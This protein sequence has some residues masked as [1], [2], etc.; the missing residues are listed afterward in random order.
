MK[1]TEVQKGQI[2][3][4][5]ALAMVVLLGFTAVAVDGS[6]VYNQRRQ[7]QA[8]AD[9][10]ALSYAYQI[11]KAGFTCPASGVPSLSPV[12]TT[13][14]TTTVTTTYPSCTS[15][16]T[17]LNIHTVVASTVNTYFLKAVTNKPTSTTVDA[18]AKVTLG[19][20]TYAGGNAIYTTGTNCSEWSSPYG[21][22]FVSGGTTKIQITDGGIFS[23]SCLSATG[24][25]RILAYGGMIQYTGHG[26]TTFYAGKASE[27]PQIEYTTGTG[28][29][30]TNTD[31]FILNQPSTTTETI[32]SALTQPYQFNNQNNTANPNISKDLWPVPVT[33]GPTVPT[34][35]PMTT[36]T[37]PK[38]A[39]GTDTI[40]T[41]PNQVSGTHT[42][43][44]TPGKISGD[45]YWSA[46]GDTTTVTFNPGTYCFDGSLSLSGS[47]GTTFVMD[48]VVLYFRGG[49][50]S[51][52]KGISYGGSGKYTGNNSTI[53]LTN[54]DFNLGSGVPLNADN[55]TIYIYRG[56]FS[57]SGAASGVMSAPDCDTSACGVPPAIKGVLLYMAADNPGDVSI[58]ASGSA[59]LIGTIYAPISKFSATGNTLADAM[60]VQIIAKMVDVT[61][62]STITMN[63]S[64]GTFYGT[65]GT[66]SIDLLK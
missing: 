1:R 47:S 19:G 5:L 32:A 12:T 49:S 61:G 40:G 2:L 64:K 54:G 8:T 6:R 37:C 10:T 38:N 52:Y 63:K 20:G 14:G 55:I 41:V 66:T 42:Y 18:T 28:L 31:N 51:D 11:A 15:S 30:M 65:G 9:S 23:A 57:I 56:K 48:N 62:S 45:I 13:T 29:F 39:D 3:A 46:W 60:N 17:T 21:G 36:P 22:I 16:P 26:S 58:T 4:I 33:S 35:E 59:S 34:M 7:D 53:Y 44:F 50:G 43:N 24:D 25:A 27:T